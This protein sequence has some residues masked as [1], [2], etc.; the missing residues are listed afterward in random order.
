MEGRWSYGNGREWGGE[1][2]EGTAVAGARAQ[3]TRW[4]RDWRRKESKAGKVGACGH[5]TCRVAAGLDGRWGGWL[6]QPID[7]STG[8]GSQLGLHE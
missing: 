1:S 4:R 5:G 2:G 6:D 8:Q 3:A 7:A